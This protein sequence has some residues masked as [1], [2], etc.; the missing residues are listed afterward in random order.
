MERHLTKSIITK[1]I[2]IGLCW[3]FIVIYLPTGVGFALSSEYNFGNTFYFIFWC[4]IISASAYYIS[5]RIEKTEIWGRNSKENNQYVNWNIQF[6]VHLIILRL[7]IGAIVLFTFYVF[8]YNIGKNNFIGIKDSNI[9][10]KF[11]FNS[12]IEPLKETGREFWERNNCFYDVFTDTYTISHERLLGEKELVD[13][14]YKYFI[15]FQSAYLEGYDSLFDG[16]PREEN[17]FTKLFIWGPI[18]ISEKF[19]RTSLQSLCFIIVFI[20]ILVYKPNLLNLEVYN[21]L[22]S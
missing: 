4:I 18:Y 15:N 14:D 19:I 11:F 6:K 1:L 10:V 13:V 20:I 7:L 22:S 8:D 21:T 3:N 17:F 9:E 5:V 16:Y 12:E 2:I